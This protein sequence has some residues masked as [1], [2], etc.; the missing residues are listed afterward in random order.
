LVEITGQIA[1]VTG[2][3]SGIGRALC[4]ALYAAGA[5]GIACVDRDGPGAEATAAAVQGRAYRVDVSKDAAMAAM[6]EQVEA[7]LGPIALFA[8]NAG[9]FMAGGPERPDRDWQRVWEVN[10]LSQ[11]IA[12]RH[13][14]P[15]MAA[16]GGG[17]LL[18]TAS[19]AG[20]LNQVGAAP[21]AVSKHAAVGLAEWL[22]FTHRD[23]GIRVSVLCPQAVESAM[24]ANG[25]GS[26][27]MDG[28]I[29]AEAC[30]EACLAA[31]REE[32]FLVLPHKEVA[33]YMQR[34]ASDTDRWLAGM[35][36]LRRRLSL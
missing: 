36:K 20:L 22:A 11:V 6:I 32:R 19:A 9:I 13:M 15:R 26:A 35:A 34:K 8:S 24:T 21:Y 1:V 29:S 16:R 33:T 2:A 30:A 18:N 7:E 14:V 25:P 23:A 17:Y 27:G 28:M 12:A 31:M 4:H 3:A 5:A 10:V